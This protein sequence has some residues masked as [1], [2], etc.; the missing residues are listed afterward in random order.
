MAVLRALG[1]E[2][3]VLGLSLDAA[4]VDFFAGDSFQPDGGGSEGRARY[5]CAGE[6]E[7]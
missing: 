3:G 4:E 1:H 5:A 2:G 6:E 7:C